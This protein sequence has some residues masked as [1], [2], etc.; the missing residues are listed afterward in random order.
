MPELPEVETI[1]RGLAATTVGKHIHAID[2]FLPKMLITPN[3]QKINILLGDSIT[4]VSRRAKYVVLNLAS[5]RRL[6]IHLRMTG[7]LIFYPNT[8]VSR[9]PHTHVSFTFTDGSQLHFADMRQFGR[10]RLI[11]VSETWDADG[12][13]EPLSPEFTAEYLWGLLHAHRAQLKNLL[14]NQNYISGL[15]N[16]YVCEALW[17]ARL[18]P[19]KLTHTVSRPAATRLHRAIVQ[20]L[21]KAIA[22]RG[23][24]IDDYVDSR[25]NAGTFQHSLQVYGR[26]NKPC[27]RCKDRIVRTIQ[28]QRGTWSCPSCQK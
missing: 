17:Q 23:T 7:R 28:A 15:G 13:I 3:K 16:I 11:D 24:S 22:A 19:I 9:P 10:L 12:G 26:T 6:A 1:A 27:F 4:A 18:S 14:L 21:E 25:G 5:G 20:I 2:V 8:D